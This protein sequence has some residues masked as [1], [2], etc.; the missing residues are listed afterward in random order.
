[1]EIL[2]AEI[3]KRNVLWNKKKESEESVR[4]QLLEIEF[5]KLAF[6][7]QPEDDDLKFLKSLLPY[8]KQMDP[9]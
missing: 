8:F 1:M 5:Q 7:N 3:Q 4:R 2:N 6:P 9:I